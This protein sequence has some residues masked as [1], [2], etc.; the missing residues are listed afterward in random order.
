[1]VPSPLEGWRKLLDLAVA[2]RPYLSPLK[3]LNVARCEAEFLKRAARLRSFPYAA[4][5]DLTNFCMLRCPYCPTGAKR[6]SGRKKTMIDPARVKQ[7]L[8][9]VG[10]YLISAALYNWGEPLLHPE[11]PSIVEMFQAHR[12]FTSISS[13]FNIK[14]KNILE[15]LCEAGLDHLIISISGAHQ[16]VYEQYHRNGNLELVLENVGYL[17]EY[18]RRKNLKKPIIELKHI[19]FNYNRHEVEDVR[20]LAA[21]L[22]VNHF[23][24]RKG[25]GPDEALVS[26]KSSNRID[27]LNFCHQLWHLVLLNADGGMAP[28]CFLFFKEDDFGDFSQQSIMEVRNN[29]K[30][31]RA[32][33]LFDPAV[34]N[35]LPRDLQHPCLKCVEVH[36]QTHLKTYLQLNPYA[37]IDHRTGGP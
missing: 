32:R 21:E 17:T 26:E 11:A 22:G 20:R 23:R 14:N 8:E 4:I 27:Y 30:F 13:N 35:D 2:S 37:K 19:V 29:E 18:K 9:E 3:L 33:Q 31:M 6:P 34:V 25:S 24:L 1:M 5:V 10:K 15:D 28:C 36:K 7:L 12:I 16:E